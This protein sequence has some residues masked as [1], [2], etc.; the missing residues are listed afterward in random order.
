MPDDCIIVV[1]TI[2]G[3]TQTDKDNNYI[4]K[5]CS[6]PLCCV[7]WDEPRA[8]ITNETRRTLLWICRLHVHAQ[9]A[10]LDDEVFERRRHLKAAYELMSQI[11][12][13][14][15]QLAALNPVA[16]RSTANGEN[17]AVRSIKE[18]MVKTKYATAV[19]LLMQ[20]GQK[21]MNSRIETIRIWDIDLGHRFGT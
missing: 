16:T 7:L 2:K 21:A 12:G 15:Q 11:D 20:E 9:S 10:T 6:I 14:N 4:A 8:P 19:K 3:T 18:E 5:I 13:P 1:H 17:D